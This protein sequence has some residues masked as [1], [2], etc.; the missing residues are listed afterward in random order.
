MG[1]P[2]VTATP[3]ML[4]IAM[5]DI[6]CVEIDSPN[7]TLSSALR[8]TQNTRTPVQQCDFNNGQPQIYSSSHM[9][10]RNVHRNSQH[11]FT[12]NN[13]NLNDANAQCNP[14]NRLQHTPTQLLM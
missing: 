10:C 2:N 6:Q 3:L 14:V 9:Y 8:E 1:R 4:Q 13:T 7:A 11:A 12:F 5:V